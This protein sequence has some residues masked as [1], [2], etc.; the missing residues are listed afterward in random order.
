MFWLL[1]QQN[2]AV[3]QVAEGFKAGVSA[4]Q[5]FKMATVNPGAL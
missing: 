2:P 4:F 3:E 1:V 5:Y